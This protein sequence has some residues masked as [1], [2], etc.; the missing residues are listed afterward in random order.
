MGIGNEA[1]RQWSKLEVSGAPPK[2]S[3]YSEL[4]V[5]GT[6]IVCTPPCCDRSRE[7]RVICLTFVCAPV[8]RWQ[9]TMRT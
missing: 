6:H 1:A 3:N 4:A 5:W 8:A 9:S 2:P 7:G